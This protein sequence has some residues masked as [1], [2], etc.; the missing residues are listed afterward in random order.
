[1]ECHCR[2]IESREKKKVHYQGLSDENIVL[3]WKL[4]EAEQGHL[5]SQNELE[6]LK[7]KLAVHHAMKDMINELE[8]ILELKR[9]N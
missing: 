7:N 2:K 5:S 8:P 9:K 4:Q 6:S 3:K 1:M